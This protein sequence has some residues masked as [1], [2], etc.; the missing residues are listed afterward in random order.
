VGLNKK[1][2]AQH[3]PLQ[4]ALSEFQN[5]QNRLLELLSTVSNA[6]KQSAFL[7]D[8]LDSGELFYPLHFT[9]EETFQFLKEIPLYEK[10]GILCR[11]PNWWRRGKKSASLSISFGETKQTSFLG[12]ESLVDFR[13]AIKIGDVELTAAEAQE[14]LKQSE[15]LALIKGKWVVVDREKL[16]QSL[17]NWGKATD[18]LADEDI[19]LSDALRMLMSRQGHSFSDILSDENVEVGIGDWFS[20]IMKK[21]QNP[22]LIKESRIA[23]DFRAE[24]RP[25]QQEGL[26]WLTLLDSLHLG[27]CLAD[28][29]G[30]GKTIQILALMNSLRKKKKYT[31]SL[32]VLPASL[33]HNWASEL[34]KFAPK[35]K[36]IIAHPGGG[37]EILDKNTSAYQVSKWD[38][39]ITTYGYVKRYQWIQDYPWNYIILDEA[40]AIKN[41]GSAQS[42]AVKKLNSCNRIVLTGTPIENR[43][44]D[45]WSLFDFLN[46]GLLG[47]KTEFS[48]FI[49]KNDDLG[50]LRQVISP[51][52]LRRLKT[53][54]NVITDLPDKI[55][56]DSFSRLSKKQHLL[57]QQ[58]VD[59]LKE[60]LEDTEG[61]M[62]R[63]GLVLSS[64]LK[65]KQI[66]NHPDQYLGNPTYKPAE[67]GK[68]ERLREICE[69]IYEKREKVLIFTQFKEIIEPLET[70]LEDIFE[71][72]GLVLHGS[73][74]IARRKTLVDQFQS[75]E[76]VPFFVLSIKAG[77]TG[78]NLTA[79]NHVIHFDRW[80]NPAV[81]N[82]ATDRAFRIGQKKSVVVHKFIT[83]GT[84]EEKIAM[85]LEEKKGLSD[86]VLENTGESSF[87][88]EMDDKE[89]ID[90]FSLKAGI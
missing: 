56:V 86:V 40:Q 20:G 10:A 50:M 54:K 66:C 84:I 4:Y 18:L 63:K 21:M 64:L 87:M 1:K 33:I 16:S 12:L 53:D 47:N 78:L 51:Y 34:E 58:Q 35:I 31:T 26:N 17:E 90:L 5:D 41:A 60:A 70:F 59:L 19:A 11:I 55:E 7:K 73:T 13:A 36:F 79:A 45:L 57:Y 44:S 27:A 69:T 81:E 83:E 14:I 37:K 62:K 61:G 67:S 42:R 52:I 32:L 28:D 3:R 72:K 75:D 46:P 39:I 43:L 9:P 80:W 6:A 77:G 89:L 2:Q 48:R 23:K 65:F 29:M 24:L 68:F 85:M 49:K 38:M 15:G 30:L 8:L 74:S 88:T 25:Y 76:Y 82:Q 71:R 22:E